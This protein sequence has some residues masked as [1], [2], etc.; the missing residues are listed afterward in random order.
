MSTIID[1]QE[2][3]RQMRLILGDNESRS[4]YTPRNHSG[5][6]DLSGVLDLLGY[7]V[8]ESV[9]QHTRGNQCQAARILGINRGTIRM[10]W[11]KYR[12]YF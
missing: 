6:P 12:R 4:Q 7:A 3:A 1:Q 9:L 5:D 11:R 8:I 10:H 2:L